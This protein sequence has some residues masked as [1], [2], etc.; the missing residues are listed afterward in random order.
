MPLCHSVGSV[1]MSVIVID[2]GDYAGLP[3]LGQRQHR[4][5]AHERTRHGPVAAQQRREA[6]H[7]GGPAGR[8]Q[9]G[10]PRDRADDA[11]RRSGGI[12]TH[13]GVADGPAP[14]ILL[15]VTCHAALV[16]Q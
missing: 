13:T 8:Q 4:A 10:G 16:N 12:H 14:G 1:V 2:G 6:A 9:P 3:P 11:V 15:E 5:D 7:R